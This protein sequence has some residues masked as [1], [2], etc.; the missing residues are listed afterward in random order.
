MIGNVTNGNDFHGICRYVL[1]KEGAYLLDSNM[2]GLT[3]T[4]LAEEFSILLRLR[5]DIQKPVWHVSLSANPSEKVDDAKWKILVKDYL[6]RMEVS[7]LN[8][9]YFIG[10][11][12]DKDYN[13]VHIVI[14]RIGFNGKV[15]HNQWDRLRSKEICLL[16]EKVHGL[17]QTHRREREREIER[18]LQ[19]G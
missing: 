10:R 12:I 15:Y 9:Q 17:Q 3:S 18:L 11:H 13:H 4:E 6:K 16:L 2:M 7:I 5:P 19:I 14:N 8:Y 1:D